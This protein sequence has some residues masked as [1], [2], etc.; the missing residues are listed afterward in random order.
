MIDHLERLLP[1]LTYLFCL[2]TMST[3]LSLS[4]LSCRRG[5]CAESL[6]YSRHVNV[7]YHLIIFIPLSPF[8]F[9]HSRTLSAYLWAD[10]QNDKHHAHCLTWEG[11]F[12]SATL[13]PPQHSA[14]AL[15]FWRMPMAYWFFSSVICRTL[16]KREKGN[17]SSVLRTL[18]TVFAGI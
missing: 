4:C 6:I 9:F 11:S 14:G 10:L 7:I 5:I 1:I 17:T 15:V 3:P 12:L 18:H 2:Q 8:S 13:Y 16:L